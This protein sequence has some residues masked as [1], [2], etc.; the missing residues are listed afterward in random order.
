VAHKRGTATPTP[1]LPTSFPREC[2]TQYVRVCSDEYPEACQGGVSAG[3]ASCAPGHSGPLCSVCIQNPAHYGGRNQACDLCSEAG[4][5]GMTLGL[6]MG[7]LGFLLFVAIIAYVKCRSTALELVRQAVAGEDVQA[8]VQDKSAQVSR[9][10]FGSLLGRTSSPS[11]LGDDEHKGTSCRRS[12]AHLCSKIKQSSNSF[13]V[14]FRILVSLGQ[15]R[16]SLLVRCMCACAD[17]PWRTGR[18]LQ[19]LGKRMK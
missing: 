2:G 19:N 9:S 10:L 4:D 14:K 5:I 11:S 16:W 1:P 15:V 6:L 3:D 13:F 17:L 12:C 8:H 7:S 18:Y